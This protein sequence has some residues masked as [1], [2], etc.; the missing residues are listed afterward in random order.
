MIR[1]DF[2]NV[3]DEFDLTEGLFLIAKLAF[4]AFVASIVLKGFGVIV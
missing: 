2:K 3:E 4:I 1:E